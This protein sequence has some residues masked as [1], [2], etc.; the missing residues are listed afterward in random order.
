MQ[1]QPRVTGPVPSGA[2]AV[3]GA[4]GFLGAAAVRALRAAGHVVEPYTRQRSFLDPSVPSIR[5]CDTVFW[6]AGST[7]PATEAGGAGAAAADL[8]AVATLLD[9]LASPGPHGRRR[10]V[11]ASSGGTVYDPAAPP[12]HGE[13]TPTVPAN[14]YGEA[15]LAVE[16]LVAAR[17][18]QWAVL[19]IGNAYGPG[20]RARRG[21]GVLAHWLDAAARGAPLVLVGDEAE[22]GR[23]H[24]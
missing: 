4:D 8:D 16:S 10:V 19:R 23:A 7:R 3:V 12:P 17:A 18:P 20:Q 15:M 13:A 24:V 1:G 22:I 2:V 6:L 21:Q 5:L 9:T 11:V 14:A